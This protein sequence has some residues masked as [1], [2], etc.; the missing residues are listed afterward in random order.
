MGQYNLD[1]IFNA[2]Q[3]A[4]VGASEKAGTIGNALMRSLV[5]GGFSGKVL[6]VN[7]KY[8]TIHGKA[9]VESVSVLETGGMLSASA[10]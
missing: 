9:C 6:P 7:P 10:R 8:R 4:V 1:R 5:D 2:R 3:V